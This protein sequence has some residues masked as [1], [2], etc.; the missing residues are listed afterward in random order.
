[1][2]PTILEISP[3]SDFILK[4]T[5]DNAEVVMIDFKPIIAEGGVC[6][7]LANA[8]FFA[9]VSLGSRGR[10]IQWPG[11]IDFCADALWL[12]GK[13]LTSHTAAATVHN[14]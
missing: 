9:Q 13:H 7:P 14:D 4:F 2:L 10:F 5:Y 11:E 1:M 3:Q 12:E 8:Q 6:A